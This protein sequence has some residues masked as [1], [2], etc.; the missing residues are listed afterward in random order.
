MLF[1]VLA[2]GVFLVL[3]MSVI[4]HG[5]L[6]GAVLFEQELHNRVNKNKIMEQNRIRNEITAKTP[7]STIMQL[8]Y[9]IG[10]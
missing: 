3:R 10:T 9:R 2:V 7:P 4:H 1:T 5:P 6:L 8:A